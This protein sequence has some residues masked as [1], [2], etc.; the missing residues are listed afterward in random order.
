MNVD[1][2]VP[3]LLAALCSDGPAS[4]DRL[5]E[6][7]LEELRQIAHRQLGRMP[8]STLETTGLVHEAYLKLADR[9]RGSWN[10][11]THFLAVAALAMRQ[12]LVDRA[13]A[14]AAQKRGGARR[15]VSL[16]D[17]MIT[18]EAQAESLIEL[19][20]GLDRLGRIDQRLAR[21]VVYR[22]FGGLTD[23]EI[24]AAIG[25]NARTVRR[26]WIKA[27][28]LLRIELAG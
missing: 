10:D 9:T 24:A 3:D 1:P 27:R 17:E 19:D 26:D 11:R 21:V 22:F 4:V 7:V 13:R 5:F 2:D 25:V 16:D 28:G 20:A 14:V 23:D 8:G 6:V 18:V 12:V 15:Q